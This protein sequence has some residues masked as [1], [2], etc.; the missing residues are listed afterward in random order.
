M[1]T[2][3]VRL[4]TMQLYKGQPRIIRIHPYIR[5]QKRTYAFYNIRYCAAV[6]R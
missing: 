6:G 3:K 5:I 4:T 2:V 1:N